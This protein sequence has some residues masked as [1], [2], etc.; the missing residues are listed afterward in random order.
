VLIKG[1]L[2]ALGLISTAALLMQLTSGQ[3][4]VPDPD[5]RAAL[6]PSKRT[7]AP[8]SIGTPAMAA[9]MDAL[10][11][12]TPRTGLAEQQSQALAAPQPYTKTFKIKAHKLSAYPLIAEYIKRKIKNAL[13]IGPD[14]ESYKWARKAA[15]IIGCE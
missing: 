9:A 13:I 6:A 10:T 1:S 2:S 11:S 15:E 7:L 4:R 8:I 3:A 5:H 12:G 14:W